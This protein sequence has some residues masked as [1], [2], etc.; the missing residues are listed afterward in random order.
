[1]GWVLGWDEWHNYTAFST[2]ALSHTYPVHGPIA[3]ATALTLK[4]M[5]PVQSPSLSLHH[6]PNLP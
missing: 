1:M 3:L 2:L 5:Y 4:H 6:N